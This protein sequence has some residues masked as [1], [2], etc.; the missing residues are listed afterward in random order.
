MYS[1]L[2]VA[3]DDGTRAARAAEQAIELA[4]AV[5]STLE[6]VYVVDV[7]PVYSRYGL[8]ALPTEDEIDIERERGREIVDSYVDAVADL[9]I[10]ATGTVIRG[11]PHLKITEH[12]KEIDTDAI[13]IGRPRRASF[14]RIFR[15]STVD[16]VVRNAERTVIVVDVGPDA[17]D[18]PDLADV[19]DQ[20]Q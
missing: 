8:A 17:E 16:R 4:S 20:S 10:S 14:T 1:R 2:L 5:G 19:V 11:T 7:R 6:F 18:V 3:V 15:V 13:V 12:A 9:D